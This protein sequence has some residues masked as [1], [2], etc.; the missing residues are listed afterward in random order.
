MMM[1]LRSGSPSLN[2]R[3]NVRRVLRE[4][5]I[6]QNV[7]SI[8]SMISS[9]SACRNHRRRVSLSKTHSNVMMSYMKHS[10]I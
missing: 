10:G 4:Y 2:V 1:Y 5:R 9:I 3:R 7:N 8:E 6:S